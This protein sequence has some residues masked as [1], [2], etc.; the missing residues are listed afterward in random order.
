[1]RDTATYIDLGTADGEEEA[2]YAKRCAESLGWTF[3]RIQGDPALLRDLL[4]GHWDD[5]RFLIVSPGSASA[6]SPDENILRKKS[7]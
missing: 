2:S 5:K 3:E 4:W 6:H 7:L 1:M